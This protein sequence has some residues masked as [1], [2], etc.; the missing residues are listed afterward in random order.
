MPGADVLGGFTAWSLGA[1]GIAYTRVNWNGDNFTLGAPNVASVDE[2]HSPTRGVVMSVME[3][4][5][6]ERQVTFLIDSPIEIR[7]KLELFDVQGRR[8]AA[9]FEGRLA[10]GRTTIRWESTRADGTR[11]ASG[12]YFARLT[13]AGG[14]RIAQIV[15]VR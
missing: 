8:A 7:A 13:F 5:P 4:D 9:P 10:H 15:V 14:N 3:R 6:G 2:V 11:V 12:V 1:T